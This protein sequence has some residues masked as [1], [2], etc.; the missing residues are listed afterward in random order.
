VSKLV[1]FHPQYA[2]WHNPYEAGTFGVDVQHFARMVRGERVRS[3]KLITDPTVADVKRIAAEGWVTCDIETAPQSPEKGFTGKDPTRARLKVLGFGN[4]EEGI[5]ILWGQANHKTLKEAARALLANPNIPKVFHNGPWFDLRVLARHGLP[6]TSWEDTRDMRRAQSSTSRLS[7]AY[8]ASIYDYTNNWKQS[9]E[10]ADAKGIIFTNNAQALL[11]YNAQDCVETARVYTALK[12]ESWDARSQKLLET[13]YKLSQITAEMHDVGVKLHEGNRNF[14]LWCLEQQIEERVKALKTLVNVDGFEATDDHMRALIYKRHEWIKRIGG[15]KKGIDYEMSLFSLPDPLNPK[16]YTDDTL[17]TI[18]VDEKSLLLLISSGECP[19]KLMPILD[20]WW[21]LQGAKKQRGYVR[22]RDIDE[23]LGDDGRIRPSWN[24]CGTETMRFS[25]S[26]P[27]MMVYQQ[28]LRAMFGME[29]GYV[30]VHADKSQLEL[31][32]MEAVANDR[33]LKQALDTGDVYSFDARQWYGIPEGAPVKKEARKSSKIIHLGS[34]YGAGIGAIYVQALMQ[35]RTFKFSSA[36]L[37]NSM[38]KTTY[39]DTVQYWADEMTRVMGC[40]YSEGRILGGRRVYPAQPE[41]SEVANFPIQ[42]TAAEMMNL[43]LIE[44]HERLKKEVPSAHIII[45]LHDAID[46][47]CRE[48]DLEKVK[49]L[50]LEVMNREWAIDG[51]TRGFPVEMK[52]AT[53]DWSEV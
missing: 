11:R 9:E 35:D 43:E 48:R 51:R 7:L 1:T 26:E 14:M 8:L 2:Y 23:A 13:H 10:E 37:L 42:R 40:G 24:S 17:Q 45:Q 4:E 20:A 25:C 34:Q 46:V 47:E 50:M 36:R 12:K 44:L 39:C 5:A 19:P 6:V 41:L 21:S 16:M 22:S 33:A 38:W 31:R 52:V 15:K 30:I 3:M 29:P 18:S 32:V 28:E 27:P 53:H 49:R